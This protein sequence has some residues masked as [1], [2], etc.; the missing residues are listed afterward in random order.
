MGLDSNIPT[1]LIIPIILL[2][3]GLFF[4]FVSFMEQISIYVLTIRIFN[5][6]RIMCLSF[7]LFLFFFG[8]W[9]APLIKTYSI[10]TII[11]LSLLVFLAAIVAILG[12]WLSSKLHGKIFTIIF[13][14]ISIIAF[15]GSTHVVENQLSGEPTPTPT[16]TT[17]SAPPEFPTIAVPIVAV[18]GLLFVF[19]RKKQG[20]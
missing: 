10:N 5:Q 2:V 7:G 8:I 6:E 15:F 9:S 18:L 11:S 20:L 3:V 17:T 16:P 1:I 4:I 14:F 12:S 13:L 19:G